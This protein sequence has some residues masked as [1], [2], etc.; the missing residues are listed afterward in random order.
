MARDCLLLNQP[1]AGVA[2]WLN[3]V[4]KRGPRWAGRALAAHAPDI[5]P[6]ASATLP[7]HVPKVGAAC[8]NAARTACA[9]MLSNE[10]P[11]RDS[12]RGQS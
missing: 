7:R 4:I 2:G 6:P 5:P 10:R 3:E 9:G 11:R 1:R 12:G 8:G